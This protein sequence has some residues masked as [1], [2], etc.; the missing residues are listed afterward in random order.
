MAH[1]PQPQQR[2]GLKSSIRNFVS[3]D[4][5]IVLLQAY[6]QINAVT[7]VTFEASIIGAIVKR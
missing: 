7:F 6:P 5:K 2:E 3:I 4:G 1:Q